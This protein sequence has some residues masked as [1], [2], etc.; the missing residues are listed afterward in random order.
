MKNLFKQLVIT[1]LQWEARLVLRR[2]RPTVVCITGSVGKTTT[3]DAIYAAVSDSVPA[4]KSEKSYNSEFGVPLTVLGL[5]NGWNNPFLWVLILI[6]GAV[7]ALFSRRYPAVLILETGVDHPGDMQR[8]T[9]WLTPDVVVLTRF[10]TVPVHVEQFDGPEYVIEEKM[11]LPRA[12]RQ[13]GVLIINADDDLVMNAAK[14]IR[15]THITYGR[16]R[17][18]AVRTTDVSLT[19]V[20]N[21]PAGTK[22]TITSPSGAADVVINGVLGEQQAYA[23]AAAAAV[24]GHLGVTMPDAAAGLGTLVP[25]RGRMRVLP[26]LKGTTLIDDTYNSSP[27]A[28]VHAL[29]TLAKIKHAKRRIVVMGDMLELGR[30]SKEE[31]LAIGKTVATVGDVLLTVGVRARGVARGALNHGMDEANILQYEKTD[32]A[33][34]ELQTLLQPGDVVLVK[35]SQG[36]RMERIVKE[37]MNEPDRASELL[38]RQ[39]SVWDKR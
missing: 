36:I 16:Y 19:Y 2:H 10:P 3:K 33:G 31:H 25:P 1:V 38:V 28:A 35:G 27:A 20:D 32:R 12:L 26:G 22:F 14:E 29:E 7:V 4:R 30:F 39:E 13:N 9:S 34:R 15:Q 21:R 18:A 24:A 37:V 6:E 8:L 5:R 17:E 11:D 23:A